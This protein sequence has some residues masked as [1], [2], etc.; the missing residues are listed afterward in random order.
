MAR[1]RAVPGSLRVGDSARSDRLRWRTLA[2]LATLLALAAG[3]SNAR[4]PA[5][6]HPA[7]D[8]GSMRMIVDAGHAPV[9]VG[10]ACPNGDVLNGDYVLASADDA[11]RIASCTAITGS[12]RVAGDAS[13]GTLE[14][15]MLAAVGSLELAGCKALGNVA[16]P[17]LAMV[18][19]DLKID[20]NEALTRVSLPHLA[21]VGGTLEFY[22]DT[23]LT[24][25]SAPALATARD[26]LVQ[27]NLALNA[28]DLPVLESIS[29]EPGLVRGLNIGQ[30]A[31]LAS[32]S[33]PALNQIADT[34]EIRANDKLTTVSMPKLTS[35]GVSITFIDDGALTAIDLPALA[36]AGCVYVLH[37]TALAMLS[38]PKLASIQCGGSDGLSIDD[39]SALTSFSL[40]T[41]ATIA[42]RLDFLSDPALA[43]LDLPALTRAGNIAIES[44]GLPELSLP[45]LSWIGANGQGQLLC[46]TNSA[47]ASVSLPALTSL[48]SMYFTDNPQLPSCQIDMLRARLVA[49]GLNPGV[50]DSGNSTHCP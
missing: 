7:A 4:K 50:T 6:G 48:G 14:L 43:Q 29:G 15:P 34:V 11:K 32:L 44:S 9:P 12:L 33:L 13:L 18:H 3:C 42:G 2:W 30:N 21:S 40:S 25:F 36:S 17:L 46:K 47:L 39:N 23:R 5:A 8:A 16:L 24:E 27:S 35:V 26:L 1:S 45:K 10:S 20:N 31:A 41:L 37:C 28:L 38:L 19:G 49:A 22:N